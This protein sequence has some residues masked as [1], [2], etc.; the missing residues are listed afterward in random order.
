MAQ[1]PT[2]RPLAPDP[3]Q[4]RARYEGAWARQQFTEDADRFTVETGPDPEHR[5]PGAGDPN[6]SW[7]APVYADVGQFATDVI[8]GGVHTEA[9]DPPP[10]VRVL[11]DTTPGHQAGYVGDAYSQP[12]TLQAAH[13]L[14]E[15]AHVRNRYHPDGFQFDH[16]HYYDL[17]L[18]GSHAPAIV[19]RA[20]GPYGR[21]L[22][23]APMNNVG[24]ERARP[25]RSGVIWRAG[26][27]QWHNINRRFT[28]P[29]RAHDFRWLR[30]D[31]VTHIGD[32]PPPAKPDQ[33]SSPFSSLQRFRTDLKSRPM[34][35]RVP[36]PFD[37]DLIYDGSNTAPQMP[38]GY[39]GFGLV[40]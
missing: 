32:A 2:T 30:P 38:V 12:G 35:R 20:Q 5:R 39:D 3:A 4:G 33:Y 6:P 21:G 14:D 1:L 28:P 24:N 37:E 17:W 31:V 18:D 13:A 7:N 29:R 23:S 9:L 40:L 16:E 36:A 34:L 19:D 15:G 10:P 22:T 25:G 8:P 26:R 11:D 27:Y